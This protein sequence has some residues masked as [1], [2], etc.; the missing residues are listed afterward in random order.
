MIDA[1]HQRAQELAAEAAEALR[2]GDTRRA[3]ELFSMAADSEARALRHVPAEKVRTTSILAVSLASLQFKAGRL[4]EAES[5]CRDLLINRDL[6]PT[7]RAQLLDIL[8]AIPRPA[9][10]G[11]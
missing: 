8:A 4:D 7:A 5:I 9:H 2:A 1:E 3:R 10:A 11:G 6:L